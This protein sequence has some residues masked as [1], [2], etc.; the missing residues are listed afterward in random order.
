MGANDQALQ[1]ALSWETDSAVP[2]DKSVWV[3]LWESIQGDFNQKRSGG[4]I[5]FDMAV[6]MVPLVD[7]VCDVRDIIANCKAIYYADEKAEESGEPIDKSWLYVS[8]GLTLIGLFP[9]LGS[10]VKGVLKLFFVF[11]RRYGLEHVIRAVEEGMTWVV[12][13]LRKR[14]VQKYIGA[15]HI[16]EIF[17]W[18]AER[19]REVKGKLSASALLTNFDRAIA[20]MKKLLAKVDW[21][22]GKVGDRARAAIA[23]VEAIRKRADAPLAGAIGPLNKILDTIIKRL[24]FENLIIRRGI[25]DVSNIHFRG[26]LPESRAVALMR[27]AEPPPKWLSKGRELEFPGL[28]PRAQSVVNQV[29]QARANGW[30]DVTDNISSFHKMEAA[31]ITGPAK[32]YRVVSPSNGAMGDCWVSQEVW[33]MIQKSPDPKAAWRKHLGVWP[34]WNPNGQF[35]VMDIPPGETV[36]VWRGPA[37]SQAK[38]DD[39]DLDAH[40]EGGWEQ[41]VVKGPVEHF[42]TT[43]YYRRA[44]DGSLNAPIDRAAYMALSKDEQAAYIGLREKINHPHIR[45][46]LDTKWGYTDFDSQLEDVKI[47]LPALPGQ[48]VN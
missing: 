45:G 33:D 22:P 41:I 14:E 12:T 39:V 21:M 10:L 13:Y 38:L 36:K 40:L 35:V 23:V 6:S 42:D 46:P 1:E 27:E 24:E 48:T 11:I 15:K 26:G 44:A 34:D 2:E 8:L 3:W 9:S 30:P 29:Q 20:L 7:Q 43:T 25:V 18:L 28:D 17:K 19:I 16:D 32:L 31:T 4:Q 47:G 5:A 37:A